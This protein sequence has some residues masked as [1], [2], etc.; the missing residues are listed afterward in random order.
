MFNCYVIIFEGQLC[1][2]QE[3]WRQMGEV[4]RSLCQSS[5]RPNQMEQ[6]SGRIAIALLSESK[7][8][9]SL[10]FAAFAETGKKKKSLLNYN[11]CNICNQ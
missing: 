6:I 9:L 8:K 11:K 4:F 2:K 5:Q 7:D 10:P 1:T 3:D